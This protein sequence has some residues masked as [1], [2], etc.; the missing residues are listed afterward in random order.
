MT[1]T[2]EKSIT[3]ISN[4]MVL[5]ILTRAFTELQDHECRITSLEQLKQVSALSI[6]NA[7]KEVIIEMPEKDVNVV[8][9]FNTT[10]FCNWLQE[11]DFYCAKKTGKSLRPIYLKVYS[12]LNNSGV[13][14]IASAMKQV[15]DEYDPLHNPQKTLYKLIFNDP[16]LKGVFVS[17]LINELLQV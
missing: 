15:R 8:M 1:Q 5:A 10:E 13:D 4:E 2:N 9:S 16:T 12:I 7:A 17:A 6:D 11:A 14:V 3:A